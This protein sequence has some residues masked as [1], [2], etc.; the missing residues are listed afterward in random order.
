MLWAW[1]EKELL[2]LRSMILRDMGKPKKVVETLFHLQGEF[3]C[4][5]RKCERETW[6]RKQEQRA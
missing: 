1:R 3:D 2:R 6:G 4:G 5:N